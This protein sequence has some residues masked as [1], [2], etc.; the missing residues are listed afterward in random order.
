MPEM[1]SQYE[2]DEQ[3]RTFY[4]QGSV[5]KMASG[6]FITAQAIGDILGPIISSQLADNYG[7]VVAAHAFAYAHAIFAFLY[8]VSCGHFGMCAGVKPPAEE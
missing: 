1:L 4:S 8:F 3:L 5:E 7:F 6:L 2:E